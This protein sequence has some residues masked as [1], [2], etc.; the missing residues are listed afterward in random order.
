[1]G[2]N[3]YAGGD[4]VVS[5]ILSQEVGL[6]LA[7]RGTFWNHPAITYAGSA[8][9]QGSSTIKMDFID[10]GATKMSAVA[11]NVAV[12][13]DAFTFTRASITLA[14][15]RMGR[16]VGDLLRVLS[17]S[18]VIRDVDAFAAD[19]AGSY[20]VSLSQLLIT[21]GAGFSTDISD[22]GADLT[23]AK[24]REAKA[25]L[26]AANANFTDGNVICVLHPVQYADLEADAAAAG[27]G[28]AV[29]RS[30]EAQAIQQANGFLSGFRG[31]LFG[32]DFFTSTDV[33][34]AN[35]AAD[36]RGFMACP[37]GL[38]WADALIPASGDTANR[39]I[40]VDGGRMA[41]E[42]ER[43]A[44]KALQNVYYQAILGCSIGQDSAGV[45]ITSDA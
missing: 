29:S 22:T 43:D 35:A 8:T 24:I 5:E 11:S 18:G 33:P 15:Q 40:L 6:K 28:D 12:T 38:L 45:T 42:F 17:P 41:I 25:T 10:S 1:M 26:I 32:I 30:P 19:A 44:S 27:I 23:W 34:T 20:G 4:L 36:R 39:E 13:P 9:Y 37:S 2:N 7:E 14:Q 31:S 21:A 3:L 16:S